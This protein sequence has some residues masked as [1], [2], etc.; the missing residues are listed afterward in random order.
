MSHILTHGLFPLIPAG[1]GDHNMGDHLRQS[2][3]YH[4][5]YAAG[6]KCTGSQLVLLGAFFRVFFHPRRGERPEIADG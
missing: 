3:Q 6:D 4:P 5:I 1:R 2:P